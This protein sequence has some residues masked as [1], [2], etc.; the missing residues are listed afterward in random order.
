MTM[1]ILV[2]GL[3]GSGKSTVSRFLATELN[4][5][6][7]NSD[8]LRHIL[9]PTARD[10]SSKETQVVIR[11]T[12]RLTRQLLEKGDVVILDALFT[13]QRPR[14]QYRILAHEVGVPFYIIHVSAPETVTKGR[15]EKRQGTGDASEATFAYYLDRKPHFEPVLGEHVL[16]QNSGDLEDLESQIKILA[17]NL[18]K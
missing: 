16:I 6:I 18:S 1:L 12:E 10:Y 2:T 13:K 4:A 9:F 15:L 7:V 11:E 5:E 14:N 3:P 17:S 8:A